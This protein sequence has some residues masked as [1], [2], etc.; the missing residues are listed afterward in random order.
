MEFP[1]VLKNGLVF[2]HIA[3]ARAF[4]LQQADGFSEEVRNCLD[5]VERTLDRLYRAGFDH[6]YASWRG[7]ERR[8][9]GVAIY[10][11]TLAVSALSFVYLSRIR[12]LDGDNV[13]ALQYLA[14]A[15]ELYEEAL[16]TP[17]GIWEAWPLGTDRPK[18]DTVGPEYFRVGGD[19]VYFVTGLLISVS[20]FTELLELLKADKQSVDDWGA[21]AS[22]CSS[23]A[24][25]SWSWRFEEFVE[26]SRRIENLDEFNEF[27]YF[28]K[29]GV[30]L[31][32]E[33]VEFEQA[34]Y[35]DQE[36]YHEI[37]AIH[38]ILSA[39]IEQVRIPYDEAKKV[40]WG[41]FWHSAGAWATAQL[42]PSEYKK[43][44]E[45]DEKDAAE[46]RLTN[47]FFG[48]DWLHLPERVQESLITADDNW[49]SPQKVRREA[50]LNELLKATEQMC[51][52]YIWQPLANA[53]WFPELDGFEERKAE[54]RNRAYPLSQNP[55]I[56]DL[57]WACRQPF[58][59]KFL[60]YRQ[61]KRS[62]IEFLTSTLPACCQ[63]L[64][65]SRNSFEH[66]LT[67]V[68]S[69]DAVDVVNHEFRT[70]LG[71]GEKGVLPELAGIGRKIR[72]S[73]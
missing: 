42:S 51:Y 24:G 12:R 38:D 71:I 36:G 28:D 10:H 13:T 21:V 33:L 43:L 70:F 29:H 34:W 56:G 1:P 54:I 14:R 62:E 15:G 57:L 50:I 61:L 53:E 65:K 39:H 9:E 52:E 64:R 26:V 27:E 16:P 48:S 46:L 17:M 45:D 22:A 66:D 35:E 11:S 25:Q 2:I 58:F 23:L 44:R 49:Y 37:Y 32:R 6:K 4:K 59:K 63:R 20:Q 72:S 47:Y 5:D 73:R 30:W 40:K 67:G 3:A 55:G 8:L 41:E 19:F 60:K 7:G 68:L 31:S 18:P 69:R